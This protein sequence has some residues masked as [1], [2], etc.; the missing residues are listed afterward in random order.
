ML[1]L[2]AGESTFLGT[3]PLFLASAGGTRRHSMLEFWRSGKAGVF[4]GI[5]EFVGVGSLG[6][7]DCLA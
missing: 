4:M 1:L 6:S 2:E 7:F 5:A 3:L